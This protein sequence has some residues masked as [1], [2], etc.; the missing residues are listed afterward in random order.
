MHRAWWTANRAFTPSPPIN[1][2]RL[3]DVFI[4]NIFF[5]R[6]YGCSVS[7]FSPF[8]SGWHRFAFKFPVE[9]TLLD[10]KTSKPC[11]V[12]FCSKWNHI[13]KVGKKSIKYL[14]FQQITLTP[15]FLIGIIFPLPFL[16]NFLP[17]TH[18]A[19]IPLVVQGHYFLY[20]RTYLILEY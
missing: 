12:S 9:L 19:R 11:P 14:S 3:V 16:K 18:F 10:A 6:Y 4:N 20:L 8:I 17:L 2:V 7:Q 13:I 15:T 5:G 1:H